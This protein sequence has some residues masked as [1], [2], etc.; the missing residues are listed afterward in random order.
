MKEFV[1]AID[2]INLFSSQDIVR[3][4]KCQMKFLDKLVLKTYYAKKWMIN[5]INC[6]MLES[7]SNSDNDEIENEVSKSPVL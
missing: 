1:S 5:V 7:P 3:Q 4:N 6:S 2:V